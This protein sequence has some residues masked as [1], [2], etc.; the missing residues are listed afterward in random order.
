MQE[1]N[2][3]NETQEATITP[4]SVFD[5]CC[6]V[7]REVNLLTD[8]LKEDLDAAKQKGID[9]V[10]INNIAK[11]YVKDKV[12][13]MEDKMQETLTMIDNLINIH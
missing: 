12:G 3:S 10:L 1:N 2:Q 11:A 5:R 4:E 6:E 7:H 13:D 8:Q 9:V